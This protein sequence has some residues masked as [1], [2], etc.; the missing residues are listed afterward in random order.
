MLECRHSS[1]LVL[2]RVLLRRAGLVW[3]WSSAMF[4]SSRSDGLP[5]C[6]PLGRSRHGP[7][8]RLGGI[9]GNPGRCFVVLVVFFLVVFEVSGFGRGKRC[10]T[11]S[12]LF[13]PACVKSASVHPQFC[14]CPY[15]SDRTKSQERERAWAGNRGSVMLGLRTCA[16]TN[17]RQRTSDLFPSLSFLPFSSRRACK[18][19]PL[20]NLRMPTSR[21]SWAIPTSHAQCVHPGHRRLSAL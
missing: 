11:F 7:G 5:R 3:V 20:T 14:I 12:S 16:S 8:A 9:W 4:G 17:G 13:F 15:A 21:G 19:V 1:I 2:A 10:E 6:G 18:P